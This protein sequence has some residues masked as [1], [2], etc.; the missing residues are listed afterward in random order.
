[1][2]LKL[3]V[4]MCKGMGIGYKNTIVWNIKKDLIYFSNKTTGLYGK[5][6]KD[7]DREKY[8]YK[9]VKKNAIVM[10]K[11]TWMSLPKYPEPLPHRDNIIISNTIHAH[12]DDNKLVNLYDM[13]NTESFAAIKL[14]YDLIYYIN[15]EE[16][17]CESNMNTALINKTDFTMYFSSI[18]KMMDFCISP[19]KICTEIDPV[20]RDDPT[21]R[22]NIEIEMCQMHEM[23][24]VREINQN[25]VFNDE[26]TKSEK[27]KKYCEI[28]DGTIYDGTIY[29]G[30]IYD[31]VWIIGGAQIYNSFIYE[32]NNKDSNIII[33]EFCITYI[34]RYY[35][36]DTFFPKIE[37]MNHYYISSFSKCE[38]MD[39]NIGMMVPVYYITFNLIDERDNIDIQKKIVEIKN[40]NESIIYYYYYIKNNM[41]SDC[42]NMY[43][44]NE[45]AE[46]F[47]WC[48][49][50]LSGENSFRPA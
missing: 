8:K 44:T 14:Y 9:N 43:I 20:D 23:R 12:Q 24:Q 3:I 19:E 21:N 45:N 34:D 18:S 32:N 15:I 41:H 36:C 40:N 2:K 7:K 13:D 47:I 28:Y 50:Q 30:K 38:N 49:T 1:M 42:E 48:I 25:S 39:A 10:G 6:V 35:E 29:D 11:N 31:E 17:Q 46:T 4:A 33:S 22:S 27:I 5:Y 26:N 16:N 37:N